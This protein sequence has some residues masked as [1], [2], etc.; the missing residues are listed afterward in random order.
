MALKSFIE[1]SSEAEQARSQNFRRNCRRTRG[2][3]NAK[4]RNNI[5]LG[6]RGKELMNNLKIEIPQLCRISNTY[7]A[8]RINLYHSPS[9]LLVAPWSGI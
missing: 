5:V 3:W 2:K 4:L 1:E 7:S 9:L 6:A 8:I